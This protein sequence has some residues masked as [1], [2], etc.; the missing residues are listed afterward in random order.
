MAL[1]SALNRWQNPASSKTLSPRAYLS[2]QIEGT[3]SCPSLTQV[4]PTH[5]K[6]DFTSGS[7]EYHYGLQ[8]TR[9]LVCL[10]SFL[11]IS[12]T[13]SKDKVSP[14]KLLRSSSSVQRQPYAPAFWGA[15]KIEQT[16]S[17]TCG[18]TYRTVHRNNQDLIHTGDSGIPD[19]LIINITDVS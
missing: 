1:V 13:L 9:F 5:N 16:Y 11:L 17:T 3:H 6:S 15:C 12:L 8:S 7:L 19:Q 2:P 14:W 18:F 10:Y 4:S